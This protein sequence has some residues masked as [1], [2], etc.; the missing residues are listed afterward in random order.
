MHPNSP[1]QLYGLA[2]LL[3]RGITSPFSVNPDCSAGRIELGERMFVLGT[4]FPFSHC[5][6]SFYLASLRCMNNPPS[7]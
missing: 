1:G 7:S 4:K 6:N 2:L 5:Y 3:I